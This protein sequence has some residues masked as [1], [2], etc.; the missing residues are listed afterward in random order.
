M[1]NRAAVCLQS[2]VKATP[3]GSGGGGGGGGTAGGGGDAAEQG[4]AGPAVRQ[5][6]GRAL[7][8]HAELL[9]RVQDHLQSQ[10][11]CVCQF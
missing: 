11:I 1:R 5:A 6:L 9:L 3:H 8:Q 2:I 10:V 4:S 7:M